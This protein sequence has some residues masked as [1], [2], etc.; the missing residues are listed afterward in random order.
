[1]AANHKQQLA[2]IKSRKK[3]QQSLSLFYS[4]AAAKNKPTPK[5]QTNIASIMAFLVQFISDNTN[6]NL[7]T[8]IGEL[9][10]C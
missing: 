6:R 1:M 10:F 8:S 2:D 5:T 4:S 3:R 9:I 7:H